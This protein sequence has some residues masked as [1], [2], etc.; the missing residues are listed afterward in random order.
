MPRK[1]SQTIVSFLVVAAAAVA[2]A[3][4]SMAQTPA[5]SAA[6]RTIN[7]SQPELPSNAGAQYTFQFLTL[8]FPDVVD[9]YVN[10]INDHGEV[11]GGYTSKKNC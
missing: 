2:C 3:R 7:R 8:P 11:I 10:G 4:P 1:Q 9:F 6:P 5:E